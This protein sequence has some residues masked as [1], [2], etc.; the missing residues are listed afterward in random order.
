MITRL[1][2]FY[3]YRVK[4]RVSGVRGADFV[5]RQVGKLCNFVVDRPGDEPTSVMEKEWDNLI[6]L[7]A[8]RHDFLKEIY[9]E[10]E[11]IVSVGSHSREFIENTFSEGDFSDIVYVSANPHYSDTWFKESTGRELEDVFHTVYKS[12]ERDEGW[13]PESVLTDARSAVKLFPDNRKIIHFMQPHEPFMPVDEDWSFGEVYRGERS[14][15]ELR[16]AYRA[17]LEFVLEYVEELADVLEGKTV[18]TSDHGELL[19]EYGLYSHPY[20]VEA[21]ELLEVPWLVISEK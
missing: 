12:F 9:P 13:H 15:E 18:V 21:R 16:E 3:R 6:I 1:Y 14:H 20:G 5:G 11:K 7:D 2:S 4:P 10:T 8:C 19:G 17:N